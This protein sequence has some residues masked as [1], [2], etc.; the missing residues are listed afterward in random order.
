MN[1]TCSRKL[2]KF[3]KLG[4]YNRDGLEEEKKVGRINDRNT[5]A[6]KEEK[7]AEVLRKFSSS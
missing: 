5:K 4:E 1:I 3:V 7:T 2:A 6:T